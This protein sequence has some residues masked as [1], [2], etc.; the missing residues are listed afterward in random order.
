[1]C[2]KEKVGQEFHFIA[3]VYFEIYGNEGE[4]KYYVDLVLS[5]EPTIS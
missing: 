4:W 5:K 2:L 3:A 1:M